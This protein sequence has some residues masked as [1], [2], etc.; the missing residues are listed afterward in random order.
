MEPMNDFE[1]KLKR[2]M[3]AQ[4]PPEGFTDRVLARV[5]EA[6]TARREPAP[7]PHTAPWWKTWLN[8]FAVPAWRVATA[9]ALALLL[10]ISGITGYQRYQER[11]R[12]EKALAD[13]MVAL[14]ITSKELRTALVEQPGHSH[15]VRQQ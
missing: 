2:A 3:A 12:A 11:K 13:L 4:D 10:T 7:P 6:E 14:Q 9:A 1:Q 5:R 8:V 15:E